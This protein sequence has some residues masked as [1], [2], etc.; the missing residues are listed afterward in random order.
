MERQR[1]RERERPPEPV[2]F[3]EDFLNHWREVRLRNRTGTYVVKPQDRTWD[4]TRQ[5][6]I[7]FYLHPGLLGDTALQDWQVFVHRIHRHSGKHRHQGGLLIFVL[8]GTGYTIVNGV[9]ENW[10]AG[11]LLLL[12]ITP[13]GVEHQHFNED[14]LK[15]AKWLAFVYWPFHDQLSSTAEQLEEVLLQGIPK[16]PKSNE[17]R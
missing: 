14:P 17:G 9:R 12:P 11:D 15:P 1:L 3:Y 5:G 8:E 2:S 10:S 6:E 7:M 13:G 4:E 16:P